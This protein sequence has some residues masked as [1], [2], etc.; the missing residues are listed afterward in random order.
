MRSVVAALLILFSSSTLRAE[1]LRLSL[2]QAIDMALGS[3]TQTRLAHSNEERARIARREALGAMLPQA[4]ARVLRYNQSINLQ[5][6]G[7]DVPGQPPIAGPFNVTDGQIAANIQLF[8]YA[9]L[10]RYQ[11][12]Q[13][14]ERAARADAAIA[15]NQAAAAVARLYVL[16]QR[17]DAQIAS[18]EAEIELFGRLVAAAQHEFEVGTGTRLDIAQQNLQLRRARQAL[19]V[20][21]NER[22]TVALALLNLIG[23]DESLD[24]VTTDPLPEAH[25]PPAVD[26]ALTTARNTRPDLRAAS[27]HEAEARLN[28]S[29][30]RARRLPAVAADFEGDLSGNHSDDLRWTRRVGGALSVPIFRTDINA[31]IARARLQLHDETTRREQLERDVE[32]QVR[33]AI[34]SLASA[35]ERVVIAQESAEVAEQALTIARDRRSAGYGSSIEVDRA[36]DAYREAREGLIAA[37]AEAAA[38]QFDLMLATGEISTLR[39]EQQ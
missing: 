26:Q 31:N 34:L 38:A 33:G 24:I 25:A 6:F 14:G 20:A 13:Q 12:L 35:N 28:F 23:A 8:N 7:F 17:A 11:A 32:Q 10:R 39:N 5:T 15:D 2:R 21:K 9:A 29:A 37:R 30:Q 4:D 36:E 16:L 3:G 1:E 18:R 27:L 19:L 22:R